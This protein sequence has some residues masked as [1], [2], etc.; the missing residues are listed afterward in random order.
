[1]IDHEIEADEI[2][3]ELQSDSDE[4]IRKVDAVIDKEKSDDYSWIGNDNPLELYNQAHSG[5]SLIQDDFFELKR[6]ISQKL[7]AH[8]FY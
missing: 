2:N 1:M 4:T 7:K 8:V 6:G 5:G 3:E